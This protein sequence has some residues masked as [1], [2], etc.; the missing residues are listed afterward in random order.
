MI[1]TWI[2][3]IGGRVQ[4]EDY[5]GKARAKGIL[6]VVI[7][8]G[9]G[10][11]GGGAIA[12][13]LLVDT[14]I[15]SFK[16]E[17]EF[18]KEHLEQYIKDAKEAIVKTAMNDPELLYMSSTAAVLMIKGRRAMWANVGDSR[19]YKFKNGIISEVTE[20][21][22]V[23]FL[24]F[25]NGAIEYDDIRRSPNQNKLTNAVGVSMDGINVAKSDGINA[26]AT[27]L[28]CTDGWWEYVKEED[29]ENTLQNA[30]SAR[31]WLEEM[32]KIHDENAPDDCDNY[33]A[34]VIMI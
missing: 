21:H 10:G 16:R 14:V 19:I 27:F 28:M 8:D 30:S 9:L 26:S 20:D 2:T 5:V 13:K 22:S 17:P 4:N 23:A 15:E 11:H 34:A 7:A 25:M 12:S 6:M 29:M 1:V 32:V 18:S 33:T 3:R 24:D 31:N